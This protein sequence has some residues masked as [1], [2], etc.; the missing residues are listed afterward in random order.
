MTKNQPRLLFEE[1]FN[2]NAAHLLQA[3]EALIREECCD[4]GCAHKKGGE[5]VGTDVENP[6]HCKHFKVSAGAPIECAAYECGVE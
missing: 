4:N 3:V 6:T 2:D 5:F 1:E